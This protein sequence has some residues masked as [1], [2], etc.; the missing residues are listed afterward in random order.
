MNYKFSFSIFLAIL[1]FAS[2]LFIYA[3]KMQEGK[4]VEGEWWLKNVIDFKGVAADKINGRKIIISSGS[5]SLFSINSEIIS[6]KT[7]L[8]V[9][10]IATHA[11]LDLNYHFYQLKKHFKNGDIV[12]M[13]LEYEYYT[14]TEAPTDWFVNNI[15]GWGQDYLSSINI[16]NRIKFMMNVSPKRLV[17]GFNAEDKGLVSPLN[18]VINH[19]NSTNG[20]Y[21]GYSYKSLNK[22][23][24]INVFIDGK[25]VYDSVYNGTFTYNSD[26]PKISEHTYKTLKDIN[27]FVSNKGGKLFITWPVTMRNPGFD[28]DNGQTMQ[29]L[30]KFKGFLS[31]AGLNV[32]CSP[33]A[34]NLGG[35][36]F[37]DSAYHTNGYGA[38]IRSSLLGDC[39]NAEL[40]NKSGY[41]FNRNFRAVVL[42]MER[43][44]PYN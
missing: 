29:S 25:T 13:P 19:L 12:V 11:G 6:Q 9:V 24:D 5:N 28:T 33:S 8:P 4:Q 22:N 15:L 2:G 41:E 1:A 21:N 14:R 26:I 43:E 18:D 34:S 7:S 40:H 3:F 42:E 10:N 16:Y 32:I 31:V 36:L 35:S 30:M 44:T 38:R 37:M 17:E 39:I 27:N 20:E 23:G